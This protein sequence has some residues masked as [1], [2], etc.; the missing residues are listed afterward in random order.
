MQRTRTYTTY[1]RKG[2]YLVL[3]LMAAHGLVRFTQAGFLIRH[4]GNQSFM[5]TAH[6]RFPSPR[7]MTNQ[8]TIP[9]EEGL[10]NAEMISKI[11]SKTSSSEAKIRIDLSGTPG[12][13][14]TNLLRQLIRQAHRRFSD[15][16][17]LPRLER[18]AKSVPPLELICWIPR[19]NESVT[20]RA[21][22][23]LNTIRSIPGIARADAQPIRWS[24]SSPDKKYHGHSGMTSALNGL[25]T[26]TTTEAYFRDHITSTPFTPRFK[27]VNYDEHVR[28]NEFEAMLIRIFQ[29]PGSNVLW[30]GFRLRR[31]LK[32][33]DK[34]PGI[35][36]MFLSDPYRH[37]ALNLTWQAAACM[38][39]ILITS[40]FRPRN[41]RKKG[42]WLLLFPGLFMFFFTLSG[43]PLDPHV[44][45]TMKCCWAAAIFLQLT[46]VQRITIKQAALLVCLAAG[47]TAAALHEITT[48]L[49]KGVFMAITSGT[50]ALLCIIITIFPWRKERAPGRLPSR[51]LVS[52]LFIS[53]L[54]FIFLLPP[55]DRIIYALQHGK[56]SMPTAGLT[57]EIR[58]V[59][60]PTTFAPAL[61]Y[62]PDSVHS[63]ISAF[64]PDYLIRVSSPEKDEL[65]GRWENAAIANLLNVQSALKPLLLYQSGIRWSMEGPGESFQ[66]DRTLIP[67]RYQIILS[68]PDYEKLLLLATRAGDSLKHLPGIGKVS[69]NQDIGSESDYYILH[70]S[71][72][73]PGMPLDQLLFKQEMNRQWDTLSLRNQPLYGTNGTRVRT[74]STELI[75]QIT[76]AP[77][78]RVNNRF[79]MTLDYEHYGGEKYAKRFYR[80]FR[81]SLAESLPYSYAVETV[82]NRM[83]ESSVFRTPG[84]LLLLFLLMTGIICRISAIRI[85]GILLGS[86]VAGL[87]YCYIQQYTF[88]EF[89]TPLLGCTG[90][91]I[92][93]TDDRPLTGV[94][95]GMILFEMILLFAGWSGTT[96]VIGE[97]LIVALLPVLISG[98]VGMKFSFT[99]RRKGLQQL[100]DL[101]RFGV[102][103]KLLK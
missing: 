15:H 85:T 80:D 93:L 27:R 68:G 98:M 53:V 13:S 57:N 95:A 29:D 47:G 86:M 100:F 56:R 12:Q 84:I 42:L 65:I 4:P 3:F 66:N 76:P 32:Q 16:T 54:V 77:V 55:T 5:V 94:V 37:A 96:P 6:G 40:L 64:H 69:V 25:E 72:V 9:L 78:V 46:S 88:P 21:P 81:I 97:F 41:K 83:T 90:I 30:N 14:T 26:I 36:Y 75:R 48:P 45:T 74:G 99:R 49:E 11:Y 22:R 62:G 17:I 51:V 34:T 18:L 61:D 24:V 79:Q 92:V 50:L 33:M 60:Y 19:Q 87:W 71:A 8:V 2:F 39:L 20:I 7:E 67:G 101:F 103:T 31:H 73:L 1:G 10:A 58:L 70:K 35:S 59:A 63:L 43:L 91:L 38:V 82:S 28:I 52:S 44:L 102:I 23:I 89:A